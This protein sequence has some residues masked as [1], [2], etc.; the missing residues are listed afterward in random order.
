MVL[1]SSDPN[2]RSAGS[3]FTNP[4]VS[5]ETAGAVVE[6]ALQRG[7][8]ATA[9]EVPHYP[10][11]DG[12]CKLAA[13]WLIER[14]GFDKGMRRGHVGLSSRHALAVIHCGGGSTEELIAFAV[15]IRDRVSEVF[16]VELYPE[17]VML[18]VQWPA[19][20]R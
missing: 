14:A 18:G 19:L 13:G 16:G 2:R 3:F 12:R 20:T 6:L 5:T 11:E 9:H 8:A 17:P 1:D 10:T 7:W 15:T 4:V